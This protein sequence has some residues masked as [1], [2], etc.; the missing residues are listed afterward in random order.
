MFEQ[1]N[2]RLDPE[3]LRGVMQDMP[4]LLRQW[5]REDSA[6]MLLPDLGQC[7]DVVALGGC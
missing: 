3:T 4:A 6:P 2:D 5:L 1:P 7:F